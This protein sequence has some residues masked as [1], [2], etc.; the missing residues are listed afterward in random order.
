MTLAER[1]NPAA[2]FAGDEKE[3]EKCAVVPVLRKSAASVDAIGEREA[4]WTR[5]P[6][7]SMVSPVFSP[8]VADAAEQARRSKERTGTHASPRPLPVCDSQSEDA[9]P[10]APVGESRA[11]R[12]AGRAGAGWDNSAPS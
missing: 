9:P 3:A 1:R 6:C 2:M 10:V 5:S 7:P 8:P 12:P 11:D 4:K